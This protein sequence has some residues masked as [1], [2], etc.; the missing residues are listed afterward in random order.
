MLRRFAA[1]CLTFA[2]FLSACAC[3][4]PKPAEKPI[5]IGFECNAAIRYGDMNVKG[6][7]KRSTAG[8]LEMDI[9]EPE[10]LKGMSMV[11]NGEKITLKMYGLSFDVSPD[12]IPQSALGLS[13]LKALD[14]MLSDKGSGRITG[15]GFTTS[16]VFNGSKFE[17]VSDPSTGKLLSLKIPSIELSADFTDFKLLNAAA[18][19]AAA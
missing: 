6:H 8:T 18:S 11:W 12:N 10:T 14:A 13:I 7:L 1:L 17:I 16:G 5:T 9:D 15:D 19:A 3:S 4:R 2:V